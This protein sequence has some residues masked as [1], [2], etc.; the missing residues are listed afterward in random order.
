MVEDNILNYF[1]IFSSYETYL[2]ELYSDDLEENWCWYE[3]NLFAEIPQWAWL[4]FPS[5]ATLLFL[6]WAEKAF[7]RED[8]TIYSSRLNTY[9]KWD[10]FIRNVLNK[11]LNLKKALKSPI[12]IAT[13]INA[14]FS[15]N[16]PI[17]SFVDDETN[18]DS[19]DNLNIY[20]YRLEEIDENLQTTSHIHLDFWI[21]YSWTPVYIDNMLHKHKHAKTWMNRV[22]SKLSELFSCD[23]DDCNK[24]NFYKNFIERPEDSIEETYRNIMWTISLEVFYNMLK[25]FNDNYSESSLKEFTDS[26]DKA[27]WGYY[28][29]QNTSN[30]FKDFI[31][32]VIINFA[33]SSN[34]VIGLTP[35]DSTVMGWSATF[36][37]PKES[38]RKHFANSFAVTKEKY[39]NSTVIYSNWQDWI[40]NRWYIVE[41][42]V[43]KNIYSPFCNSRTFILSSWQSKQ[44]NIYWN[45][46][47]LVVNKDKWIVID[48][49]S[50]KI[51]VKGEKLTSSDI[52]SQQTAI[53]LLEMLLSNPEKEIFNK[54]LP[55]SSYS[56]NRNDMVWK[57]IMPLNRLFKQNKSDILM[58][59]KWNLNEYYIKLENYNPDDND[60]FLLRKML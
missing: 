19:F 44:D 56:R 9:L 21:L 35:N 28:I 22:T 41:Q 59:C 55:K 53:A 32:S 31:G 11:S 46:K 18:S 29:T 36:I 4:G 48:T 2:T 39:T 37:L 30:S 17:V 47:D 20:W 43:D 54:D 38:Y 12:C 40:E 14:F 24:P 33:T 57:I 60:I 10:T 23:M 3:F 26:L 34:K 52:P 1:P 49:L 15:S 50:K 7:K 42:D 13:Q 51:Y 45:Y 8:D 6:L 58:T 25:V 5:V 16:Y 27:R